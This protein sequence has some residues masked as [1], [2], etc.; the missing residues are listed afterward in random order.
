MPEEDILL[1]AVESLSE[2]HDGHQ[3]IL[4]V[5]GKAAVGSGGCV[6]TLSKR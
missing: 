2:E 6:E 3:I 5:A 4:Q 1:V